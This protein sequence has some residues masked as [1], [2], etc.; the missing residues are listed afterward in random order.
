[1]G[2]HFIEYLVTC[3]S[4]IVVF[5]GLISLI[6]LKFKYNGM[7][8]IYIKKIASFSEVISIFA[9]LGCCWYGD[10]RYCFLKLY[11]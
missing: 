1:V 2:S 6:K 8:N 4:P 9:G 7:E 5:D 10:E 3:D 11:I